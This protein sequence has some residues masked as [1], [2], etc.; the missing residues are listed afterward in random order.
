MTAVPERF[1]ETQE[2]AS[3]YI[4]RH[5]LDELMIELGSAVYHARPDNVEHFLIE[6]LNM[7]K[8][9]RHHRMY[10]SP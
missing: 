6:H 9:N 8:E 2:A 1:I 7:R 3:E 5:K 10:K 4:E